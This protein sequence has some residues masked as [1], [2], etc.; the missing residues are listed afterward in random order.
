MDTE[1][2]P[3]LNDPTYFG[4]CPECGK[5]DGYRNVWKAHWFV[6]DAHRTK[7]FWGFNLVSTWQYETEE[8]WQRNHEL[9]KGYREV[10]PRVL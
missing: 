2:K 8:D 3:I 6:C 4:G 10:M 5:N 9:L 1:G 7:W